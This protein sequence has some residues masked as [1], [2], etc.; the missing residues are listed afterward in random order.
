[1]LKSQMAQT[2]RGIFRQSLAIFVDK[3]RMRPR[4]FD[5]CEFEKNAGMRFDLLV[6]LAG[7]D[8]AEVGQA[9]IGIFLTQCGDNRVLQN[10]RLFD[11]SRVPHNPVAEF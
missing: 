2:R 8:V 9:R 6:W 1:M 4:T 11:S 3:R 10:Q 7:A 5:G